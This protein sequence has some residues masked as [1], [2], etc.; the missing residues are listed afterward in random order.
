MNTNIT[1]KS[2]DRKLFNVIIRQETKTNFLN[3]S[4]LTTAYE[5][6][7]VGKGWSYRDAN[8]ILK[9]ESNAERLFYILQ[10][11]GYIN[12]DC[13]DVVKPNILGFMEVVKRESV[14]KVLK[15]LK[16]YK[17]TGRGKNK[18][19]YT[20]PYI[21]MLIAMELHPEIYAIAVCWLADKLILN[22]IE[23]GNMYKGLTKAASTFE[24]VDYSKLATATN[25]LI[26]NASRKGIRNTATAEQL[27][28]LENL[29]RYLATSIEM[30]H[31]TT[32][33]GLINE[34]RKMYD[35]KWNPIP[36]LT[37]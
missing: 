36:K 2:E 37:A 12:G 16:A 3:V 23:A 19:T 17:T 6:E 32:F 29:E 30:G 31:I 10:K 22:R 26:F 28:E 9:T 8:D 18:T 34:L 1:M 11:R 35:K 33:V 20:D 7:R 14:I 5:N 24:D 15:K 25:C 27:R 21:W 4:D 13:G